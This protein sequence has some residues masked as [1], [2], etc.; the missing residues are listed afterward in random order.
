MPI[1]LSVTVKTRRGEPSS[2]ARPASRRTKPLSV[3]FTAFPTRLIRIWRTRV[4]SVVTVSGREPRQATSNASPFA[5]ARPRISEATAPTSSKGEHARRS[6]ASFPAS[7][8]ERSS[9]SFT[10]ASR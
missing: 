6:T 4:G 8:F 7:I 10:T 2:F 5:S 1:P 9:T 3:N